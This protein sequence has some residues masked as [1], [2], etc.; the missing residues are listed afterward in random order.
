M[1]GRGEVFLGDLVRAVAGLRPRDAAGAAAI[2]RLLGLDA[3]AAVSSGTRTVRPRTVVQPPG[4]QPA[5]ASDGTVSARPGDGRSESV[6]TEAR[7]HRSHPTGDA[8]PAS[9]AQDAIRLTERLID[10]SLTSLNGLRQT[11]APAPGRSA[12][13][14]TAVELL[15]RGTAGPG[16]SHEPPWKQVWARGIMF[17]AVAAPLESREL[18]ERSLVRRVARL[19]TVRSVPR[20]RRLSTRRGVQLL[21]DH[22]S[23]LT[24]FQD[25]RMWLHELAANVI[26]RDRVDVLRFRG[27]PDRGVVRRDPLTR[28]TYRPPLPGTPVVLFSDLGLLRPAFAGRSVASPLEWRGFL[29]QVTHSGCPLVCLTPYHAD[30]YPAELRKKVAFLPFDRRVSL[31]HAQEAARVARRRLERS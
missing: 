5:P 21:L 23:G 1:T 8:A 27:T 9:S 29:D 2:A 22:G 13:D 10:F 15:G 4:D 30:D 14:A 24:P 17:A 19:D 6:T 18:D 25:D 11:A 20:R 31:R 26:G 28:E 16:Q 12:P 3:T 7:P